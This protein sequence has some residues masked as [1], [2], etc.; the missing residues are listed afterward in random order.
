MDQLAET[1]KRVHNILGEPNENR[2]AWMEALGEVPKDMFQKE[3]AKVVYFTGCVAAYFPMTKR[4]PQSLVQIF[5]KAG[6][7][8]TLLGGEEWCCGFPLNAAGMKEK[9]EALIPI[10]TPATSGGP[11]E[12]MMPPERSYEPFRVWNWWR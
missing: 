6:V 1:L 9:A 10:M 12:F 3:K 7:D 11:V 2:S 4:I 5:E 8:F